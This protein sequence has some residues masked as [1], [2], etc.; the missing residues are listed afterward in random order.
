V[1]LSKLRNSIVARFLEELADYSELEDDKPY[2]ARAYRRAAQTINS[3]QED[4]EQIWKEGRLRDLPGV[5]ENIER[6]IDEILRTGRLESLEKMKK[7]IPVDVSSLT[8][9][10]GIGPKTVKLLYDE[11]KVRDLNELETAVK[12]G[13]L[14]NFRGLGVK[15]D[16]Q[17]L[18]RIENARL[19]SNRILLVKAIELADRVKRELSSIPGI[20]KL[21]ITGSYRRMKDTVGDFDVLIQS[22]DPNRAI[23][24]FTKWSGV[25]EVTLSGGAKTSVKI[26]QNFQVDVRVVPKESWGAALIYF[27]GSKSHN[28]ELR[29]VA[30]RKGLKLNE[31]GVF[32]TE[33]DTLVAGSDEEEVYSA[34]G[35]EYIEPELREN[36]GEIQRAQQHS[37][38][39]LVRLADIKGDLQMHTNAS[40]GMETLPA[41][42][43]KAQKLGYA[44]IAITDHVGSLKIA[45]A[46]DSER[47]KEQGK[48]IDK[49]NLEYEKEGRDFRIL[50]GA[51]VNIRS[52]GKMDLPDKELKEFE[53]V[54]GSIHGGFKDD[55]DK[56]T[57]RIAS[58]IEN[59]NVDIIAHPTG[60]LLL[61]R[62]GYRFNFPRII[63]K[64][65]ETGTVLEID[66]HPN[67]LDL[68]DEMALQAIRAGCTLSVDTD[69]HSSEE[70]EYMRI[71]VSQARR[72]WAEKE[73]ILN[74]KS[75]ADLVKF[76]R[77]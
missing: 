22:D 52:D 17:L 7:K 77:R 25:K 37:L 41:M 39:K 64:A 74:T 24:S 26:D 47:I 43:E 55:E 21:E 59:E 75:Y 34:L 31:Y 27:T 71:G 60:R 11:L 45:N 1:L 58:A 19:Q 68:N 48:E 32:R 6:K 8:R 69:S 18:E 35:L 3:E 33:D 62:S 9:V 70:L 20:K 63:E 36:R 29:T 54:L 16:Q 65:L 5:G 14:R 38:P 30:M 15:T 66:G 53:I 28:I 67:R 61:S 72:A 13:K 51:E 76:L 56:M 12:E 23:E 50:H 40:D 42:A 57:K 2:R 46:L 44:Y 49:L 4:I 73:N 10:E